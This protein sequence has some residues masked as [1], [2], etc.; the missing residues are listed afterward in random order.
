MTSRYR[1]N[2]DHLGQWYYLYDNGEKSFWTT[3]E[4]NIRHR[5]D[6]PAMDFIDCTIWYF[7]GERIDVDNQEDFERWLALRAF[8]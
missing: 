8:L 4:S 1:F 2:Q 5:I 3:P 7:N 6:G